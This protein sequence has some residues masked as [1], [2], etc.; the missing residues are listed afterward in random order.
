QPTARTNAQG[1]MRRLFAGG[2]ATTVA[3]GAT[4]D[5]QAIVSQAFKAER[6][7]VNAAMATAL[8]VVNNIR[9]ATFSLNVTPNA[10]CIDMFLRDAVGT[11]L[12][13]YTA[14]TGVGLIVNVTNPSGAGVL[15][16][17]SFIGWSLVEG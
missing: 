7:Y 6:L 5:I 1:S 3:A 17:P 12:A 15:C 2:T 14:Q 8:M 10:V 16:N 13:G 11:E 9:I 4:Q